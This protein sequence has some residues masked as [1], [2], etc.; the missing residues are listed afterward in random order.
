MQRGRAPMPGGVFY[1][2][3]SFT[4][5]ADGS[6]DLVIHFHGN[7]ELVMQSFDAVNIDAVVCILNIGTGSG[8]YEDKF[9]NPAAF[10]EVLAV[11]DDSLQKRGLAHP[12]LKRIALT[13]WSAGYGAVIRI[14]DH[15][16]DADRIDAVLLLDGLH[17]SYKEG[18]K[19]VDGLKIASVIP[20]AKRAMAGEKLFLIE[21]SDIDPMTYLSVHETT[22]YVLK[23]LGIERK[24]VEGT[25]P[26]PK[27]AAM[28]GILPTDQMVPLERESEARS[29]NF[30]VRGY[31]GTQAFHH[32][33]FLVQFSTL[34]L[35]ELIARWQ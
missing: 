22:D 14:L 6:Y 34:A 25:T 10:A 8:P 12:K 2:P 4:A 1:I 7:T 21:H 29:G 30:I 26:Y 16:Q 24:P 19:I 5:R 15:P 33:A 28:D 31:H 27:L 13:S 23:E 32:V 20:F 11:V 18:T 3:Q 35:P 17:T 9:A